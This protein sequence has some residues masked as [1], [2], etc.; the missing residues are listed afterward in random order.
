MNKYIGITIFTV[1]I[2]P[3]LSFADTYIDKYN[4]YIVPNNYQYSDKAYSDALLKE[5][6]DRRKSREEEL[7]RLQDANLDAQLN[8]L[9]AQWKR[10][11]AN[12]LQQIELEG[13]RQKTIIETERIE[14]EEKLKSLQ[15][16]TSKIIACTK[17]MGPNAWA[18]E[19]GDGCVCTQGYELIAG[20]CSNPADVNQCSKI[21]EHFEYKGERNG[22]IVCDCEA[23]FTLGK[24][25]IPVCLPNL[26]K[27]ERM[28]PIQT[29]AEWQTSRSK[30]EAVKP[31]TI[32]KNLNLKSVSSSA[33]IDKQATT[34]V[35]TPT[36][37]IKI[38]WY[39]KIWNLFGI[40]R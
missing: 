34:T 36:N 11:D 2:I 6:E 23:G 17:L 30:S 38:P 4:F 33:S 27:I 37:I 22:S 26:P 35:P 24:G 16:R 31:T 39:Q 28:K 14:G 32:L 8:A 25:D 12:A 29:V 18:N 1:V 40:F 10:E 3:S 15:D 13:I 19:A 7:K 5:Q 9:K 21:A 20:R